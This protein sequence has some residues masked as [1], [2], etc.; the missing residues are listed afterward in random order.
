M[1]V[2][3]PGDGHGQS[4]SGT[5]QYTLTGERR[6]QIR[7]RPT[8]TGQI[9]TAVDLD[10]EATGWRRQQLHSSEQ[11]LYR[12]VDPGHG[13]GLRWHRLCLQRP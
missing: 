12:R 13:H 6:S 1:A 3:S 2:R 10:Y 5:L 11:R 4:P 7:D 8:K 9:K